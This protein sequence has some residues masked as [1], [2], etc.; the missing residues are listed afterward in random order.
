ML[1]GN[2]DDPGGKKSWKPAAVITAAIIVVALGLGLGLGL[3][4]SGAL[5]KDGLEND[6]KSTSDKNTLNAKIEL[7]PGLSTLGQILNETTNV[8]DTLSDASLKLTLFAPTDAAFTAFFASEGITATAAL[9]LPSLPTILLGHVIGSVKSKAALMASSVSVHTTLGQNI[10]VVKYDNSSKMMTIA[11]AVGGSAT[12][13]MADENP[14]NSVFTKISAV[15]DIDA[16]LK[17]IA[18]AN[19]LNTLVAAASATQ[20]ADVLTTLTTP[21]P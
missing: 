17:V 20:C 1:I 12:V 7:D 5:E 11:P 21:A 4:L 19:S 14:G 16:N 6:A 13:S 8:Q 10:V 18:S 3:G 2:R 15:I 9:A